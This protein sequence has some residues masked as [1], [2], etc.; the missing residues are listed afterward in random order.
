MSTES[1]QEDESQQLL[2]ALVVLSKL[3]IAKV[4]ELG[5]RLE[6]HPGFLSVRDLTVHAFPATD[7]SDAVEHL[8]MTLIPESLPHVVSM[9]TYWRQTDDASKEV[10]TE[11]DFDNLKDNL[12]LLVRSSAA[13][14]RSRKAV[15][16]QT[17]TGNEIMEIMFVCDARPVYNNPRNEIEGYV[18]LATMKILYQRQNAATEEIEF[19]VTPLELDLLIDIAQNAK[20]KIGVLNAKM[21]PWIPN[22]IVGDKT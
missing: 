4:R 14:T 13:L 18:P 8:I 11:A 20:K 22:G 10:M 9:V 6:S 16:L 12:P 15:G 19:V 2:S 17:V 7:Q 5:D 3:P 1:N 21:T